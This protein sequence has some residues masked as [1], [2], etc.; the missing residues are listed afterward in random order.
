MKNGA[1]EIDDYILNGPRLADPERLS[2]MG[3][4]D[5]YA[6]IDTKTDNQV[7]SIL[8]LQPIE[9]DKLP[10]IF[11][12]GVTSP[13]TGDVDDWAWIKSK[14]LELRELKNHIFCRTL[15]EKCLNLFQ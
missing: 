11:D 3:F 6:A 2:L 4:L 9:G 5:Q 14:I 15:T 12:N 13:E 10:I 8:T 7:N 1:V